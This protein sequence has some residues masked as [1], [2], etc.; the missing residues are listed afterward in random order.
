MYI[1]RACRW[2]QVEDVS[3]RL[4]PGRRGNNQIGARA[5]ARTHLA[6][7]SPILVVV[8]QTGLLRDLRADPVLHHLAAAGDGRG[9]GA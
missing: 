8:L 9:C 6:C 1:W 7:L 4:K 2:Y 5:R 3:Q